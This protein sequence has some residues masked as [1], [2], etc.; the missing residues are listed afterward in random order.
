[1]SCVDDGEKILLPQSGDHDNEIRHNNEDNEEENQN[2]QNNQL[3]THDT[4]PL[5]PYNSLN[6][7]PTY[8]FLY[9]MATGYFFA[10]FY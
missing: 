6:I 3:Q 2:N 5:Y 10:F 4:Q 1:M 7:S 8:S 9:G